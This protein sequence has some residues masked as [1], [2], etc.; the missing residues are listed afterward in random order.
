MVD[1]EAVG[2]LEDVGESG[3]EGVEHA[4]GTGE[5]MVSKKHPS[6]KFTFE[7]YQN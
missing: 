3:E 1:T 5:E 2:G 6:C 4:C 7:P